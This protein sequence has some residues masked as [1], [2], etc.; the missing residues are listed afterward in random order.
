MTGSAH[1]IM[2]HIAGVPLE[3]A[4]LSLAPVL[5]LGGWGYLRAMGLTL[6]W[7]TSSTTRSGPAQPIRRRIGTPTRRYRAQLLGLPPLR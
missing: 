2:A 3:E 1:L 6:G 7:V 4:V 5:A